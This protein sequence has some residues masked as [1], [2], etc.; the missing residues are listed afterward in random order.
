MTEQRLPM[1]VIDKD[2]D[3]AL[4]FACRVLDHGSQPPEEDR[5]AARDGLQAIRTRLRAP[6]TPQPAP[7]TA[8]LVEWQAHGYGPKWWGF[9]YEPGIHADW[10]SDANNAVRFSRKED[11]ERMRLHI[12][13]AKGLKG[14][15]DYERSISATEHAWPT[16]AT[17]QPDVAVL[18]FEAA[19]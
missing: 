5:K 15:H 4:R 1:T 13:A 14:Q 17:P 16:H 9:N 6:S 12:I 2:D 8:W 3:D 7:E 19:D 11:A 18:V 10:C